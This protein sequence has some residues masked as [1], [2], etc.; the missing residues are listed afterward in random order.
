MGDKQRTCTAG[1]ALERA[2]RLMQ[3]LAQ[4]RGTGGRLEV[5]PQRIDDLLTMQSIRRCEGEQLHERGGLA[6]PPRVVGDILPADAHVK[7]AENIDPEPAFLHRNLGSERYHW[8]GRPAAAPERC[9][10]S[11]VRRE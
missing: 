1:R 8:A 10:F 9:E 7:S 6:S 4:I 2:P 5:G 3:R 11:S